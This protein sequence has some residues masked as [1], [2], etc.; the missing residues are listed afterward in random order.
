MPKRIFSIIFSVILIFTF[1][2]PTITASAF[3]ATGVD[4]S[5]KAG[6]LV[7]LDTGEILYENNIDEKVYPASI[8]KMGR[9]GHVTTAVLQKICLALGCQIGDVMEII[10]EEDNGQA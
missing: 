8:T 9:N 3:E 10:A 2:F 7:S 5:A 4:I 1:I 6:M